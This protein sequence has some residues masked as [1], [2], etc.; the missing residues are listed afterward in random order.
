MPLIDSKTRI[1]AIQGRLNVAASG[2]FD[3][4]TLSALQ[5]LAGYPVKANDNLQAQISALQTFLRCEVDGLAG[6]ETITRIENYLSTRLPQMPAGSSLRVSKKSLAMLVAFEVSSKAQYEKKYQ[7]PIWPGGES[8]VTI[9]IG[10]DLGF[11]TKAAIAAAWGHFV[12]ASD[13]A[14]LQSAAGLSGNNAK[15]AIPKTKSVTIDYNTAMSVFYQT[16]LP[17]YA[18]TTKNA[19]PG[20]DKL[21]PDAQGALL[22]LVYNRGAGMSGA[23]RT[24]MK[25]IVALVAAKNLSGIARQLRNMKRLWEGKN[26]PGLLDRREQEAKLVESASFNIL[27]EDIVII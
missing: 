23:S 18:K 14:I 22:S 21:P 16:T 8:G 3:F 19:Y 12:S 24:E 4:P 5:V 11:N 10:Y 15:N 17:I 26:L 2:I 7:K 20:I 27:S 25:N 13:L 1:K 9:G 6:P